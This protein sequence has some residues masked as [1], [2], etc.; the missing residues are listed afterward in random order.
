LGIKWGSPAFYGWRFGRP[1]AVTDGVGVL[2]NFWL[3]YPLKQP[4][5]MGVWEKSFQ[6]FQSLRSALTS[7]WGL[8]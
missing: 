4:M 6:S 8:R 3:F 1:A 5:F 2:L 7:Y